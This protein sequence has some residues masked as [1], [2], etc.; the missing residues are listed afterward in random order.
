MQSLPEGPFKDGKEGDDA[1]KQLFLKAGLVALVAAGP[2]MLVAQQGS[3][4]PP[5]PPPAARPTFSPDGTVHV[6]AF[7]LPPSTL[8]SPEALAAQKAR[9]AMPIID[10]MAGAP[11]ADLRAMTERF[12]VPQVAKMRERYAVDIVEQ[13]IGGVRTRIITPRAGEA[14]GSRVLINL[15]GGGFMMCAEGCA[16]VESIPIA[17]LGRYKVVTVDYR[18]GPENVFP[19]ASQDVA[20]VYQ[21]LLK[22]YRPQN[23]GIY[24]CSAGGS[25]TAQ[26]VA[27]FD[28]KH[29]PMPG[30]VGIFGAGGVRFGAGDSAYVAGYIDAS[31][32]PPGPDGFTAP[33]AYFKGADMNGRLVSP[34]AYPDIAAKFPPTLIITGTRAMDMSP[35]IYTNN[36]LLKA[37]VRSTLIVG[38]GMGHCYIY[39]SGLP[40]ARDAYDQ[41]VRFFN[42]NL[43]GGGRAPLA[44][45]SAPAAVRERPVRKDHCLERNNAMG[46]S[47]FAFRTRKKGCVD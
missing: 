1:M 28:D 8:L 11:V 6:P 10:R 18:Q 9:A 15:H 38:E 35:A 12:L 23:I 25:L 5:S 16:M 37:G 26:S 27:W 39:Q 34:A 29:I 4:T 21:E 20:A 46:N 17:A 45:A 44:P 41:I 19:A 3:G 2:S 14:D 42:A 36:Q 7:D 31:F 43:G 33:L 22:S 13:Q 47:K 30:A 24:G 40:E 32:P